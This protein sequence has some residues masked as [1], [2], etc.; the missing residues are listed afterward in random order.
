MSTVLLAE[1]G[2]V[3]NVEV[4]EDKT[5]G[6]GNDKSVVKVFCDGPLVG[7]GKE[8]WHAASEALGP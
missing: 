1:G 3:G 7:A 6:E 4:G 5:A 8:A 2:G